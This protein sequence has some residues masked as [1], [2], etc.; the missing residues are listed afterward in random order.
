[1]YRQY[2]ILFAG[3]TAVTQLVSLAVNL[4]DTFLS[5]VGS[6][7]SRTGHRTI[8]VSHST[9]IGMLFLTLE[10][11]VGLFL[12]VLLHGGMVLAVTDL[13]LGREAT[14]MRSLIR[15]W[16]RLRR[17]LATVILEAVAVL[18]ATLVLVIPGVYVLCRFGAC[19]PAA[20]IEDRTPRDSLS[21]SWDLTKGYTGR[22]FV[23][24]L[25]YY[26]L[27]LGMAFVVGHPLSSGLE[28]SWRSGGD[29]RAWLV[30]RQVIFAL[31]VVLVRPVA[32]IATTICY[33]DLRVRKEGFDLQFMMDPASER[34][35]RETHSSDILSIRP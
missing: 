2:F 20:L 23:I 33:F 5:P 3:L 25:L 16:E 28:A 24:L 35:A 8:S 19:F 13:Y 30:A 22:M 18:M 9:P 15:S 31:V 10:A 27:A 26:V 34:V 1:M 14:I 32:L 6:V 7:V 11:I 4:A 29:V 21:R 12:Y 17:L